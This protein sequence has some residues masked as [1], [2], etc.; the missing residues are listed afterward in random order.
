MARLAFDT[1][2]HVATS[3]GEQVTEDDEFDARMTLSKLPFGL[4]PLLTYVGTFL[5]WPIT[6]GELAGDVHVGLRDGSQLVLTPKGMRDSCYA[7]DVELRFSNWDVA[8]VDS[9]GIIRPSS[10]RLKHGYVGRSDARALHTF[11]KGR[12]K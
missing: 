11:L 3:P 6:L 2:A 8:F 12:I 4:E 1:S 9:T 10:H 5:A 7:Y